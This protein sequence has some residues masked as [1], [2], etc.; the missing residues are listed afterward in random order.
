MTQ[1]AP[2]IMRLYLCRVQISG[3]RAA[4]RLRLWLPTGGLSEIVGAITSMW[5]GWSLERVAI[6]YTKAVSHEIG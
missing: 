1:E 5:P 3:Q 6:R 2:V 4:K